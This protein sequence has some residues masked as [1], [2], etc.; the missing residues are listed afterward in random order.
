MEPMSETM[1]VVCAFITMLPFAY[2]A[3]SDNIKMRKS[4]KT[5]P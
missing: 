2:M 1:K 4:M 5:S 3:I